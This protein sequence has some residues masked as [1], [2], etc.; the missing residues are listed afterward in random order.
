MNPLIRRTALSEHRDSDHR[1][2]DVDEGPEPYIDYDEARIAD[3]IDDTTC[4]H[5]FL[6]KRI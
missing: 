4:S 1:D 6:D 5:I 2:T 3:M